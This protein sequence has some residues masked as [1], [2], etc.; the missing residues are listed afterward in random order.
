M[1][2]ISVML[3]VILFPPAFYCVGYGQ[4]LKTIPAHACV[5]ADVPQCESAISILQKSKCEVR[6]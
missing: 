4:A 2:S 1:K 5:A 6:P 3:A